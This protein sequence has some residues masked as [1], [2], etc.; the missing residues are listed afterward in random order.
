MD[1]RV[2][3]PKRVTSP[4]LACMKALWGALTAGREKEGELATTSLEFEFRLQFPCGCPLTE[5]SDSRQSAQSENG[6]ECKQWLKTRA[7]SNDVI[8][9]VISANQ[10]FASTFS[11]QIFKFQRRSCKLSFLFLPR[12]QRACSHGTPT[13]GPPSSMWTDP[14]TALFHVFWRSWA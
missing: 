1:W 8:T 14:K 10:H 5:L 3:P 6:R 12:C 4:S 13:W 9:N 2:T 7:K 11:M